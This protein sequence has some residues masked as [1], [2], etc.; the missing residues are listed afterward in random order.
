MK[1]NR[2]LAYGEQR[3]RHWCDGC[4]AQLVTPINKRKAREAGK[5]EIKEQLDEQ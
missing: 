4:D 1:S 2:K 5:K 3:T